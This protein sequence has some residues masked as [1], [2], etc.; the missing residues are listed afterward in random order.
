[1]I[2]RKKSEFIC[3]NLRLTSV[4]DRHDH[5]APVEPS[6][7]IVVCDRAIRI[8]QRPRLHQTAPSRH[9]LRS[10]CLYR[11]QSTHDDFSF[12]SSPSI[13][14]LKSVAFLY[15]RTPRVV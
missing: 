8:D 14:L 13:T 1:M 9:A 15:S 5:L 3:M 12:L 7:S 2:K 11:Y 4:S 10:V 6:F